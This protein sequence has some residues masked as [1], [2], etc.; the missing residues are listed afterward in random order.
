LGFI[1]SF[2]AYEGLALLL[3]AMPRL[4]AA[5]PDIRLLLVGGGYEEQRLRQQAQMLNIS[6][7]VIFTGRVPHEQV[8][9]YYDLVDILVYPRLSMRLTELVTP[10]KPLEAMAQG[11]LVVASDVGG[12]RELIRDG[13]TG[14][15]FQAG[16]PVHLAET[17]L[18]LL[19]ARQL[20]PALRVAARQF[21]ELERNW[22]AS[23][24]CYRAVYGRFAHEGRSRE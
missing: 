20:W 14:C 6:D 16:S 17:V 18:Q 7:Q 23:V 15:L 4:L 13:E 1:G 11:R 12:H 10:L 9:R 8:Q 5:R 3:E 24:G 21:V 22:T 19:M 2:Y